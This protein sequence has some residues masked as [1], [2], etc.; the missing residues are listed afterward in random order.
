LERAEET[1][2]ASGAQLL[3]Q[4]ARKADDDLIATVNQ[5][6]QPG[7]VGV[8]QLSGPAGHNGVGLADYLE[9]RGAKLLGRGLKEFRLCGVQP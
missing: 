7:A 2:R 3:R 8:T 1:I 4:A 6:L 9:Q 5:A